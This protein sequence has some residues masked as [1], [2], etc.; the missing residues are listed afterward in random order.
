MP[1]WPDARQTRAPARAAHARLSVRFAARYAV[2]GFI[3]HRSP[4]DRWASGWDVSIWRSVHRLPGCCAQWQMK[5]VR[6]RRFDE[7]GGTRREYFLPLFAALL[8][9]RHPRVPHQLVLLP[10]C[11][12]EMSV[13][14][15]IHASKV[16]VDSKMLS[17][18]NCPGRSPGRRVRHRR[19]GCPATTARWWWGHR[20]AP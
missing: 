14:F 17:I 16:S 3:K 13:R 8:G 11:R 9:I 19:T 20:S 15:R 2:V 4:H 1:G 5:S 7:I 12:F 18:P 6:G 10:G